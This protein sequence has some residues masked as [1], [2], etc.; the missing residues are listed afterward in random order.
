MTAFLSYFNT[1]IY[2]ISTFLAFASCAL[3]TASCASLAVYW[4]R[5]TGS[6]TTSC[7][8]TR[9]TSKLGPRALITRA[10]TRRL[11]WWVLWT[12]KN[13]LPVYFRWNVSW[14]CTYFA[15]KCFSNDRFGLLPTLL[16]FSRTRRT[17]RIKRS[18]VKRRERST[19]K[20]LRW[21]TSPRPLASPR[22][23][24]HRTLTRWVGFTLLLLFLCVDLYFVPIV[25]R[26]CTNAALMFIIYLLFSP[27]SSERYGSQQCQ[28]AH[29]I[30]SRLLRLFTQSLLSWFFASWSGPWVHLTIKFAAQKSCSTKAS[31][32]AGKWSNKFDWLIYFECIMTGL[33][34]LKHFYSQTYLLTYLLYK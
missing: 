22:S 19:V 20:L 15:S 5:A 21:R 23:S 1:I 7:W 24:L 3:C 27:F 12:F 30:F 9:F 28:I 16:F 32:R 8:S 13:L 11:I 17:H 6:L 26:L 25:T 10:H 33:C 18:L 2:I 29:G 14:L 34:T 31:H 4:S